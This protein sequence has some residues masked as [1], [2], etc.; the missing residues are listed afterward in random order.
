M[1]RPGYNDVN[2]GDKW[3]YTNH[4]YE[5]VGTA[6]MTGELRHSRLG[7][8]ILSIVYRRK[9]HPLCFVRERMEFIEKFT[10]IDG[11]PR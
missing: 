4:L 1:P 11:V 9:G 3:S 6:L 7:R 2:P 10:F 8:Q 5:V